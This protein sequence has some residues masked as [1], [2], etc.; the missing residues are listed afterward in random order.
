M[1][2]PRTDVETIDWVPTTNV[3]SG[4]LPWVRYCD[5][6]KIEMGHPRW[7]SNA[8]EYSGVY[9]FCEDPTKAKQ[10][11]RWLDPDVRY[12]G[13]SIRALGNRV[14]EYKNW[15]PNRWPTADGG[16]VALDNVCVAVL[17]IWFGENDDAPQHLALE[18]IRY[19]ERRL[20]WEHRKAGHDLR[21]EA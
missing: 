16:L 18:F 8:H 17:P 15:I 20:I 12:V 5:L 3:V 10:P 21:N 19:A 9:M 14:L 6:T 13:C 2:W 1:A 7:P 4:F 11:V